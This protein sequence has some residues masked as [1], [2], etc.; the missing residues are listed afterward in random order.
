[1]ALCFRSPSGF[2]KSK[3]ASEFAATRRDA[4]NAIPPV[5]GKSGCSL[6]SRNNRP[7]VEGIFANDEE[8]GGERGAGGGGGKEADDDGYKDGCPGSF[9][10]GTI[11]NPSGDPER[12]LSTAKTASGK[13]RRNLTWYDFCQMILGWLCPRSPLFSP[14]RLLDTPV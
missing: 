14:R 4:R 8:A 7:A 5:A 13:A 9:S 6:W 3:S 11:A 12:Q 2:R 1:M 10:S